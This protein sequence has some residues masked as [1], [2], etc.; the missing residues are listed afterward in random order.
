VADCDATVAKAADQGGT[1]TMPAQ[2]VPPGSARI[3]DG[4]EVWVP[5]LH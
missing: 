2:D 5:G 1:V 4:R 3:T